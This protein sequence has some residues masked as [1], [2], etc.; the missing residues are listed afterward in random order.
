MKLQ[1]QVYIPIFNPVS[2]KVVHNF[3]VF[4][5]RV[6]CQVFREVYSAGFSHIIGTTPRSTPYS[7]SCCFIQICSAQQLPATTYSASVVDNVTLACFLLCRDII[8]FPNK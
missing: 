1:I 7:L 2:N 4:S 5:Q 6:K 8:E 3:N